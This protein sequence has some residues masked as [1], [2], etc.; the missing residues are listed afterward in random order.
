[1][2]ESFYALLE[3]ATFTKEMLAAGVTQ[4]GKANYARKG[5]YFQAFTSL[6]TGL[7]RIG[8]L[9]L[10]LDYYINNNGRFPELAFLK[11][12]IG[13]DLGLLYQ[14]AKDIIPTQDVK[15]RFLDNL[16]ADLHQKI[17]IIL[18][19]FAKG[20]RYSNI[21]FIV[22]HSRKSDPIFQWHE[23]VDNFIFENRVSK[24]KKEK[25]KR[26]SELVELLAG[27]HMTVSFTDELRNNLTSVTNAS[28]HTGKTEA[29]AKYRQL[30]VL[31]I[32]R[33][34]VE[35]LNEL[36]FKAMSIRKEVPFFSEI[37]AI[38]YNDDS[39]FLN[40]KTFD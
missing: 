35:L 27:Q 23:R 15:F 1:M 33:Y 30:Y 12:N 3:E 21:D 18:S 25:I 8:K 24:G 7:E 39:Y 38:F 19:E 4:L 13:H 36:G 16:D 9:C 32:I 10:I 5:V 17:L 22:T 37:F 14:K 2:N 31:Q 28:F 34:W 26:N 11:K 20:D 40:R 6:A 29:V